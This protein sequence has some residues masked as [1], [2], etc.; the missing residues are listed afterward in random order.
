MPSHVVLV[1]AGTLL[2]A[3]PA[4]RIAEPPSDAMQD[5][6]DAQAFS[7]V[8]G[9]IVGAAAAC[10]GISR[11]RVSAAAAKVEAVAASIVDDDDELTTAR[12]LF[13]AGTEVGKKA[14]RNG[15][16]NCDLVD[17]SLARLEQLEQR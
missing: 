4:T 5:L 1:L 14:V 2:A 9:K 17:A 15:K 3:S 12:E 7:A 16:A 13:A 10:D 11:N 8:A 6:T